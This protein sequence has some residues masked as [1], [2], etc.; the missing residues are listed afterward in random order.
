MLSIS[1]FRLII[2]YINI[3]LCLSQLNIAFADPITDLGSDVTVNGATYKVGNSE[4]Q[5]FLNKRDNFVYNLNFSSPNT[6]INIIYLLNATRVALQNENIVTIQGSNIDSLNFALN[7]PPAFASP[8]YG[9]ISF[10]ITGGKLSQ[11]GPKFFLLEI[12]LNVSSATIT[13]QAN[14]A[15]TIIKI[16]NTTITPDTPSAPIGITDGN[17]IVISTLAQDGSTEN[18]NILVSA[19]SGLSSNINYLD[20]YFKTDYP[21]SNYVKILNFGNVQASFQMNINNALFNSQTDLI[22]TI[23]STPD[24]FANEPIERKVWRFIRDN[25]YH[26]DPMTALQWGHDPT[27]FFDSIGF[28]YCDDSASVYYQLMTALGYTVRVWGMNGHVVPEVLINGRW[29]MYDPDKAVYYYDTNG[30]IAGVEELAQNPDLITNPINPF[31]SDPTAYSSGTANIYA[32]IDDND[33]APYYTVD[34][35]SNYLLQFQVP[36][37]GSLEFPG[38]FVSPLQNIYDNLTPKYTNARLVVP[39]GSPFNAEIPLV[40]QTI[41]LATSS[42]VSQMAVTQDAQSP[43]SIGKKITFSVSASGGTGNYEYYFTVRNPNT[44]TWSVGQAYSGI[45]SWTWNT[46]GLASGTYTVQAWVRN[47]GSQSAYETFKSY[48]YTL[49]PPPAP[50]TGLAVSMDKNSPQTVGQTIAF[51][52]TASGGSGNYEYYFTVLNPNTGTWSVGQAYSGKSSWT[53]NTTGLASGAYTVQV[54]ARSVGSLASYEAFKSYLYTLN[55]PPPVTGLTSS[56]DKSSPQTVGQKITLSATASGGSGNYEYYFTVHNPVTGTWITGQAYSGKSSWTW[57]TTGSGTGT[58]TVQVWARSVGSL[59]PYEAYQSYSYTLNPPPAPVTGL[60]MSLDKSSPQTVGQTIT[61]T[62]AASGGSGSYEYYFTVHNATTGTRITGQAYSGISTW[63]WNTAGLATGAYTVQ[64]WARSVGSLAPYEAFRNYSYTINP[65]PAPV[66]GLAMSMDKSS[67][68][69]VGQK[70]TFTATASG[71]SGNYEYYYTVHNPNTEAWITG[72][73]YSGKSSWT[74]NTAGSGTGTYTVQVWARSVGSLAPYEAYKS[75]SY[76]LNPPPAPVTGLTVVQDKSSPQT[77]GQKITFTATAS[78]GSGN[79]EYYY[80]VLNPN[81]GTWF[82]GQAYS[83]IS[84]WTWDTT[85]LGTG[86]YTVQIWA[87]SV[88]SLAPYE[89]YKSHSYTLNPPPLPVTGLTSSL[90]KSSPQSVGQK[91]TFTATASGGSGNYEYYFTVLNPNTGTWFTGQAYSGKPSWTWNT[92]GLGTGT[93]TVQV[94]ARSVGSLA[95]YEA[96]QSYSYTLNPPP[97]PV[98]GL[99][100]ALDKSSPQTVGQKITFTATASGGSGNYEYYFTVRNPNTGTWSVGQAYSGISSWTWNTT[101]LG[102]GTYTVQVWARSVGSLAPYEA[103]KSYSYT[104]NPPPTPVTGLAVSM[105]KSLPR[106]AAQLPNDTTGKLSHLQFTL[107]FN[108]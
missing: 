75:Y 30:D 82:T 71:G 63:T 35:V 65:P 96:F 17:T 9:L 104:I 28:G 108:T 33:V 34:P 100:V 52:A 67:P 79:Y 25:R 85:G 14:D 4:L 29:E 55:P 37:S 64:V 10:S 86:T 48:A 60:T 39:K 18:Y 44:G 103:F 27:L 40:I 69:T 99:T 24:E 76:T 95:P 6:D 16:N 81:T 77:V 70:I 54:W 89:A 23:I 13:P 7:T 61:F 53:W 11:T 92:T 90:D 62:A 22:N 20:Y 43:Q 15:S 73:A 102:P 87:R 68:Q 59:A 42:P 50:V 57:D 74:W 26:F 78:G 45:S 21:Q 84:S 58:Y 101:G 1:K 105:D 49:N 97:A 66:T 5:D 19:N 72:Q 80:T 94:W 2:I 12:P 98:T 32:S 51:N 91:I 88:G 106:F 46:A 38:V 47:V 8:Y 31:S 107:L 56:L 93:Y 3:I 83:G 41:T 36:P